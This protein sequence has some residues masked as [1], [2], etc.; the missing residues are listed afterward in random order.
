M[1]VGLADPGGRIREEVDGGRTSEEHSNYRVPGDEPGRVS[2]PDL[3]GDIG[4]PYLN[5]TLSRLNPFFL[6]FAAMDLD[7]GAA[8]CPFMPLL[9]GSVSR[10]LPSA[11]IFSACSVGRMNSQLR[12]NDRAVGDCLCG[13]RG[14][15]LRAVELA[16][17]QLKSC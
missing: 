13:Y 1:E 17:G 11:A 5:T 15:V 8:T 7:L 2:I 6:A 10:P 16:E 4:T 12:T 9:P 14:E 3:P